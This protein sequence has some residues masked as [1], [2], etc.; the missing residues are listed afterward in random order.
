MNDF[1]YAPALV[2]FERQPRCAHPFGPET[3]FLDGELDV[4][5]ELHR[6]IEVQERRVPR[7][8]I[9]R[10]AV[11]A[12]HGEIP[13]VLVLLRK[14]ESHARDPARCAE[15]DAL[16][17]EVINTAEKLVAIAHDIAQIRDATNI[18]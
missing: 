3:R 8:E 2:A 1:E 13:E 7:V 16:Q 18:T 15:Q 12:C 11:V 6:R 9:A 5:D 17:Y 10:R 14:R 4:L